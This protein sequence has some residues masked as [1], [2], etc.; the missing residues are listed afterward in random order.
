MAARAKKGLAVD[1]VLDVPLKI[2]TTAWGKAWSDGL[3]SHASF[4]NR[5]ERGRT[6]VRNGSV[7]HLAIGAGVIDAI[8][9]G[10]ELYTVSVKVSAV[11]AKRW[12]SLVERCAGQVRSALDVL[13]GKLSPEL[14]TMLGGPK[15]GLIPVP[16]ELSMKCSCPDGVGLCKH[17]GAV[18]YG[19]GARLDRSPELLFTLRGV[20]L[21]DLVADAGATVAKGK[22]DKVLT[23]DDSGLEDLFGI[24]LGPA[25]PVTKTAAATPLKSETAR[26]TAKLASTKPAPVKPA[27]TKRAEP[28]AKAK[29][30]AAKPK[31]KST[32][33]KA[34]SASKRSEADRIVAE[35]AAGLAK[36]ARR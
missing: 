28:A 36:L 8:V 30:A 34:S 33:P 21:K 10:S 16:G 29:S 12:K 35:F 2:V 25:T 4:A 18:L 26:G 13:R 31:A 19:V 1:P 5:L 17:V 32:K 24:D 3:E 15:D 11:P 22:S 7:V 20:A 23:A 14:M 27:V 9:S 6:Y